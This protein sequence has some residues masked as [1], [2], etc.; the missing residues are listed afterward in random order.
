MLGTL[1]IDTLDG[2]SWWIL[3]TMRSKVFAFFRSKRDG[4]NTTGGQKHKKK[5]NQL[6]TGTVTPAK[7][8]KSTKLVSMTRIARRITKQKQQNVLIVPVQRK[9]RNN[10]KHLKH[11]EE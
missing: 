6:A 2:F 11:V 1:R 4:S 10:P 8:S 5:S 3:S 7:P 9:V